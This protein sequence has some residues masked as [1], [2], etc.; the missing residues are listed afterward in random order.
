MGYGFSHYSFQNRNR[1][2]VTGNLYLFIG[3]VGEDGLSLAGVLAALE[4]IPGRKMASSSW[5]V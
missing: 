1:T 3:H 2:K 4:F 5:S